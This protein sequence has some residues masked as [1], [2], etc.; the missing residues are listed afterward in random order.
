[1]VFRTAGQS[2]P[3]F[4]RNRRIVSS[5]KS[6]GGEKMPFAEGPRAKPMATILSLDEYR[7][8]TVEQRA[9]APWRRRFRTVCT[10]TTRVT[11]LDDQDLYTLAVPGENSTTAYFELIMGVMDLGPA[12][13]FYDLGENDQMTVTEGYVFLADQV[14]F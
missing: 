5:A 13:G 12:A 10:R 6:T 7:I 11:D 2:R 1:M 8:K 4:N 3:V 14:R 9:F